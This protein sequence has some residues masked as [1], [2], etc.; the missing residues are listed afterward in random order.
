LIVSLMLEIT[1][2]EDTAVCISASQLA[3]A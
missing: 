1:N 2:N 3:H